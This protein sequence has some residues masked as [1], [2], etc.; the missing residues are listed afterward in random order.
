M[1]FLKICIAAFS[2]TNLMTTFSYLLSQHYKKLFKEPVLLNYV[3]Q[4]TK[5]CPEGKWAVV[6]AWVTHYF[7]GLLFVIA[8][9]VVWTYTSV[10]FGW[11]S[12]IAFGIASGII[13]IIGWKGI[14]RL[15]NK[16]PKVHLR[17]Y[18][19]QLFFAHIIFAIAVVVA[20][21][22]Y[23]YD[24]ISHAS[25]AISHFYSSSSIQTGA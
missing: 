23:D 4:D 1:D 15:P 5:I 17:E 18:Y 7:I 10:P 19:I 20:F 6:C 9:Q 24:P 3:F 2:A 25:E 14:F 16:K 22:L 13:G 8:Y 21:K 12:G 11:L